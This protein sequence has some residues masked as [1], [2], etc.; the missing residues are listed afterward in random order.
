M[1]IF[2]LV[3]LSSGQGFD[4][5]SCIVT[6]SIVEGFLELCECGAVDG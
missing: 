5:G 2:V 4:H 1:Y 3:S 6:E